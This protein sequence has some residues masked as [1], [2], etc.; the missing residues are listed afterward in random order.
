MPSTIG[1]GSTGP[2][3]KRLQRVLARHLMWNPFGPITGSFDTS[4]ETAVKTFQ[5]SNGLIVDGIAG[6]A[7]WAALPN[8]REASPELK[9]GSHGPGVAWLQKA[10]AG[11]DIAIEFTPYSGPIDGIFG[12]GT[13]VA[14]RALQTWAGLTVNGIVGD[15]TWFAWMTPGSAQQLTL[16]GACGLTDGLL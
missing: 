9:H 3:V 13:G 11:S 4:L 6:P 1:L 7:T 10:L 16:E 2:D 15:D 12:D 8:Y 14:V 5:Q